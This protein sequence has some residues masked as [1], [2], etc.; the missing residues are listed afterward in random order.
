MWDIRY[1]PLKFADVLGQQGTVAVLQRRL[2]NGTALDMSYIFS[3]GSGQGKTTLARIFARALLC[4]RLDKTN[5]DP[6]NACDNC[7][8]IL[9]DNSTAYLEKDAA[10]QGTIDHM[11]KIVEEL[12]FAVF[13]APKRI[14]LFDECHRLSKDAQDTLLKPLEE[15][16]FVGMFCTTEPD[17]IRG[18]IRTRCEEYAIRKVTREDILVRVKGILDAEKVEHEDAGVL[19]VID[20][21]GGHVR[22]VINRLEMCAQMGPVTLESVREHLNLSVVTTYYQILLNTPTNTKEALALIDQACERV[23]PEEIAN[24]LAEAAMN[25]FRLEMGMLTDFTYA[26]KELAA[27][28]SALYGRQLVRVAELFS[29]SRYTTQIGL[30]CDVVGLANMLSSGGLPS[31]S[32]PSV[33]FQP[34]PVQ[35]AQPATVH[36]AQS[37]PATPSPASS[38][39]PAPAQP[40]PAPQA[41]AP[42]PAPLKFVPQPR[43]QGPDVRADGVGPLGQDPCALTEFDQFAVPQ[44][45]TKNAHERKPLQFDKHRVRDGREII[46]P[47]IWRANFETLWRSRGV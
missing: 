9:D 3:G 41:T 35:I 7:K 25:A 37:Q 20:S 15:K 8:G 17:K 4:E 44:G 21:C 40:A 6:C 16:K 38:P 43:G 26:D 33:A 34:L 27:K 14:I 47:A 29:K 24:G 42:A 13:G 23:T 45:K 10:S 46:P 22:E 19:T 5:P 28:T 2:S 32:Q 31:Y 36:V 39:A 11:R 1:R 12:P 18:P 30:I